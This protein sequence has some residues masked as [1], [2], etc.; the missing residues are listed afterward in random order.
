DAARLMVARNVGAVLVLERGRLLGIVTERDLATRVVAVRLDP[1][2]VRLGDIMTRAPDT[3]QPGDSVRDALELMSAGNY[4]HLPV[5]DDRRRVVG[6]VSIRDLY[7]C[8]V[9][10]LEV[11]VLLLAEGLLTG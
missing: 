10:Q 9:D 5:V 7:R 8:V 3:V 11:D 1:D 4:R 2:A 6:I